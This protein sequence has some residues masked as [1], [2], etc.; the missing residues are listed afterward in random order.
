MNKIDE[1]IKFLQKRLFDLLCERKISSDT[2]A[3]INK[4]I[5]EWR[6]S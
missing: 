5:Y 4:I 1:F 3:E 6:Q 2:I